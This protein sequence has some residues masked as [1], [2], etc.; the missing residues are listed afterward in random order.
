MIPLIGANICLNST[1]SGSGIHRPA[2]KLKGF[3]YKGT[4]RAPHMIGSM[5]DV[6]FLLDVREAQ[7]PFA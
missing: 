5:D 2:E 6:V 7:T 1:A 4:K 3:G